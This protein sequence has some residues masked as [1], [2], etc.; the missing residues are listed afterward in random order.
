M[1]IL[2]RAGV[3]GLLLW[4][5]LQATFGLMLFQKFLKDRRA[6]RYWLAGVEAWTLLYWL[7][8]LINGAFDVA[9]EGPQGGI[10]FWCVFGFGLALIAARTDPIDHPAPAQDFAHHA[11][12]PVLRP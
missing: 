12:A 5:G 4:I 11:P 10:W 6:K 3:P 8:F 9:L 7:A 1:T 2:A